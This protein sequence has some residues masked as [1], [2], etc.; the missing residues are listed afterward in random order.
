MYLKRA[1]HFLF[2]LVFSFALNGQYSSL[3]S[4]DSLLTSKYKLALDSI[5]NWEL[6][7]D[8]LMPDF[9][10]TL[11]H[12]LKDPATFSSRMDS[13]SNYISITSSPDSAL[14]FYSWDQI[15]G[16]SYHTFGVLAQFK[17]AEGKVV[18]Q[19]L[20]IADSTGDSDMMVFDRSYDVRFH[21]AYELNVKGKTQY[22]TIG[23]GTFGGGMQHAVVRIFTIKNDKLVKCTNLFCNASEL[24]I[25]YPRIYSADLTYD[26]KKRSISYKKKVHDGN[27]PDDIREKWIF[28]NG[29]F[30]H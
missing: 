14:K 13:L 16:G 27:L 4:T 1:R 26:Q 3:R 19:R 21:E 15:G 5:G 30:C 7:S 2:P 28:R 18:V 29:K 6:I 8:S 23:W 10:G 25:E 20:L 22:L 24:M 9:E 12:R 17:T 11:Q